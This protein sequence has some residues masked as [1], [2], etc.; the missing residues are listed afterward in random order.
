MGTLII[1][2]LLGVIVFLLDYIARILKTILKKL[3]K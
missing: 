3:E 2:V 1:I